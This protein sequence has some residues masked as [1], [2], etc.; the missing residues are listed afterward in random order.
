MI[1]VF[2]ST[3]PV[4]GATSTTGETRNMDRF[5]ST[6][7]VGGATSKRCANPI[8]TSNF[9]PRSPW[10]ERPN[11]VALPTI[12]ILFQS[13]LPVG[14]ATG[15]GEQLRGG[16]GISIHAPRGGSD[17]NSNSRICNGWYFN[18]RS[19]WGERLVFQQRSRNTRHFNPRSP[20]GER[21]LFWLWRL[22]RDRFQ[23]TLPVGG[24]TCK[25]QLA[26]SV[27]KFQSTLPVGG[28]TRSVWRRDDG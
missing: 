16:L 1:G 10:G 27:Q 7:P 2:Q 8:T 9:N 17:N 24:A 26:H 25:K 13:T 20:W 11:N 12:S 19:P 22:E 21:L 3:L 23:S 6:L 5:Q 15:P 18:P 28:A 14:G 4:G